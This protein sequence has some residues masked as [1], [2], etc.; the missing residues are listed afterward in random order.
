MKTVSLRDLR[1]RPGEVVM[2]VLAGEVLILTRAG[3][4]VAELHPLRRP[5]LD[6]ETLLKRWRQVP[7]IDPDAFRRDLDA[8]LDAL[9][10][11]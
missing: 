10:L 9:P 8:V 7:P 2:R 6:R 1:T 3:S 5:G 4:P 11:P